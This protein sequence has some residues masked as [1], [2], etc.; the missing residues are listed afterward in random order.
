[1]MDEGR[2]GSLVERVERLEREVEE[3]RREVRHAPRAVE[4]GV[5]EREFHEAQ[6]TP[7]EV[8]VQSSV[9][10]SGPGSGGNRDF[11]VLISSEGRGRR[12]RPP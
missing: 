8:A 11:S 12:F 2:E 5:P 3:L 1:M 7:R 6:R 9:A 4:S 10:A